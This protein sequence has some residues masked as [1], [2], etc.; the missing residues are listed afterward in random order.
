MIFKKRYVPIPI[1]IVRYMLKRDYSDDIKNRN[2]TI[3]LYITY[4][5]TRTY[6][7]SWHWFSLDYPN[8]ES[9]IFKL[10]H[11]GN[12]YDRETGLLA[13]NDIQNPKSLSPAW[14][15][16]YKQSFFI[17]ILHYSLIS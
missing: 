17:Q 3:R 7:F 8:L 12:I 4:N 13:R 16:E 11:P 5:Q 1:Y 15:L 6:L 2:E 14:M 9:V 10:L